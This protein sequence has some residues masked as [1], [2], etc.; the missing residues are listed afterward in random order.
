MYV[1]LQYLFTV[2]FT[3]LTFNQ[4]MTEQLSET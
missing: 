1:L 3:V 4:Y 2:S